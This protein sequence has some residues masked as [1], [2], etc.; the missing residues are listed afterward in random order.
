MITKVFGPPGSG[1]TTHLLNICDQ[2]LENGTDSTLIGYFAFTRKAANEARDRAVLKFPQLNPD[3]HFPWFRTLH[4][5][6]YSCLGVQNKDMMT[7]KDFAEF[8][9]SVGLEVASSTDG[10]EFVVRTDNLILNEINLARIRGLDL[11]THYNQ[12][13]IEIE[14]YH[15]EYI[16]RAYR[17]FKAAKMLMDFTDLLERILLEPERLPS[18]ELLIIDEAQDLSLLQWKLVKEL[19]E[20]SERVHIAGD[21]DQCVFSWAG[22]HVDS[23]LTCD[24][25]IKVLDQSYRVPK[26]VHMLA[27]QIVN[28]IQKRQP[29]TWAPREEEGE[30]SYYYDYQHVDISKGKWLIMAS[31]NYML[32]HMHDWIKS[33]GLLFER[34][35]H[36]SIPDSILTAVIGWERLRKG[37]TVN[38]T[39]LKNIYK[40]LGTEFVKRGHKG[41]K[42]VDPEMVYDME[43]L[44]ERHGLLTDGIWHE[45]LTKIG[46]DKREY[47]VAVLRRGAKLGSK[48][49]IELSTIHGAKGGEADNVLLLTD[50]SPKFAKDYARNADD[51]NRLLYVGVTRTKQALHIVMPK[52]IEKGFRF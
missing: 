46:E 29:K 5:L 40:Y 13:N 2:E 30:I 28:R 26:K 17:R 7:P 49:L 33:Q 10:E 9:K 21:D 42:D 36:R 6:A 1:K 18:L 38:F 19:M 34:H 32:N 50:L 31:T 20:R 27:D 14:W 35:G 47:L 16:E 43:T 41:L 4:S 22:A 45:V 39:V 23:F 37:Q 44:K 52:S 3:L 8:A 48:P 15:F 12:S 11:H 51:I 25:E 24:G